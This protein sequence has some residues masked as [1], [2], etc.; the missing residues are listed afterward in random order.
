MIEHLFDEALLVALRDGRRHMNLE[1]VFEAKLTDE[2]GLKQPVVYTEAERRSV[3]THEAGHATAA[4]FLGQTR[5]LEMLSII[6]RRGSLG[7]LARGDVEERWTR[8]RTELEAQVAISLGWLAAEEVFLGETGTGPGSDLAHATEVAAAMVGAFGMGGSLVSFEAVSQGPI[9]GK[10][11]VAKV[12]ADGDAKQR[13]EDILDAQKGRVTGL[14]VDNVDVVCA[15]RD[16]L[17]E[18]DE[19]IGDQ[20]TA[21]IERA[22]ADRQPR[23]D[24]PVSP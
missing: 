8:S 24:R 23:E 5:R 4:Y 14:L 10:N 16:A 1:H 15:L 7:L 6:K 21:V 17:M 11:L 18:R 20:I 22:L 13:L 2:I 12:L 19:L 9:D 3:A